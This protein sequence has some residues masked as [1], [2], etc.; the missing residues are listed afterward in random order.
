[1]KKVPINKSPRYDM[2]HNVSNVL[3]GKLPLGY[4]NAQFSFQVVK[5]PFYFEKMHHSIIRLAKPDAAAS[6]KKSPVQRGRLV[7]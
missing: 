6:R 7:I 2:G 4:K 1:M 3:A 5:I